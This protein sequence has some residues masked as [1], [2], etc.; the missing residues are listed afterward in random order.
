[1]EIYRILI[2]I[3]NHPQCINLNFSLKAAT[4][5]FKITNFQ[6]LDFFSSEQLKQNIKN[7]KHNE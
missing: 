2:D 7:I 4:N 3:F 6:C 5:Q 1:M